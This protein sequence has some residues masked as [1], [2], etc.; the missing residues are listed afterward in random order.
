M[1]KTWKPKTSSIDHE[2]FVQVC[3]DNAMI[4]VHF[5]AVWN[6][7]D[8]EVDREIQLLLKD[9]PGEIYFLSCNV[10][11]SGNVPFVKDGEILNFPAVVV[12]HG[13]KG[14]PIIGRFP[15]SELYVR[16]MTQVD[17]LKQEQ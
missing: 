10:D 16:I 6:N 1:E 5:W 17:E 14:K 15:A 12:V 4:A 13:V 8:Q 9:H 7:Y 3:R 11:S 2:T